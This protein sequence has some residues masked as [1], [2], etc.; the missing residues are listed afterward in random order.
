MEISVAL[1]LPR[2]ALSV[3]VI[4]QV[5]GDALRTLGAAEDSVDDALVA[6]SEACTNVLEHAG[7]GESYEVSARI[8]DHSFQVRVVDQG[9][10][11]DPTAVPNPPRWDAEGGRGIQLMR[12]L[13]DDVA[14]E[15]RPGGGTVVSLQKHLGWRGDSPLAA[16]A[17]RAARCAS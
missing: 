17:P 12:A 2:E 10:G 4:R 15:G 8:D 3:R 11:F 1:A 13:V 6:I 7:P 5:L 16:A 14:F 9:S